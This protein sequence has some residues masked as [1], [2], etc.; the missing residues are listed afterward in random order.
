MV[1][2]LL[3]P[4]D[5][6]KDDFKTLRKRHYEASGSIWRN[7]SE[8]L[9]EYVK[10]TDKRRAQLADMRRL[11]AESTV[12]LSQNQ[13]RIDLQELHIEKLKDEGATLKLTREN[14]IKSLETALKVVNF[15]SLKAKQRLQAEITLDEKQL[16]S[17]TDIS[18]RCTEDLEKIVTKG[19]F[20]LQLVQSCR[21]LETQKEKVL[22][23]SY[24]SLECIGNVS[25][26]ASEDS[27]ITRRDDVEEVFM[28]VRMESIESKNGEDDTEGVTQQ[29]EDKRERHAKEIKRTKKYKILIKHK[30]KP[31]IRKSTQIHVGEK[32]KKE[33]ELVA[34][35]TKMC[36][37]KQKKKAKAQVDIDT[38]DAENGED[39]P[40]TGV[41]EENLE[42][43]MKLEGMWIL[44]NKVKLDYVELREEKAYL[45]EEN[46]ILK[47][48]IKSLLEE[49]VLKTKPPP[50]TPVRI[51]Y[52]SAPPK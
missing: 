46:Q 41:I 4:K 45:M 36:A 7:I 13:E 20:V 37:I 50:K 48:A 27:D 51:R 9:A 38:V 21:R 26:A 3:G 24:T 16:I 33:L 30:Y 28:K 23:F 43:L 40:K 6:C 1:D 29:D 32:L 34:T 31:K 47:G 22:R 14:I 42:P 17:L 5:I 52:I 8:L 49:A 35:T 39:P 15:Q 19:E 12:E 18:K 2:I 25:S 10:Q 11:D 44:Y